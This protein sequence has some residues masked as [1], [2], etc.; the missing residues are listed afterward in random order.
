MAKS[1]STAWARVRISLPRQAALLF[2]TLRRSNQHPHE[3]PH[4]LVMTIVSTNVGGPLAGYG[5][6]PSNNRNTALTQSSEG[7]H[8]Y[9]MTAVRLIW[10]ITSHNQ[11]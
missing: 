8:K 4:P 11:G 5:L 10:G 1:E 2:P 3:G 7:L 6:P 9:S